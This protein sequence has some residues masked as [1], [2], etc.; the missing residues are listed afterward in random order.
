MLLYTSTSGLPCEGLVARKKLSQVVAHQPNDGRLVARLIGRK[1]PS[2][3]MIIVIHFA[4]VGVLK[5]VRKYD[6]SQK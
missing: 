2:I 3:L 5:G 1:N 6:F 4:F